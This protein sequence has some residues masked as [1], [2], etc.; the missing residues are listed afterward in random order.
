MYIRRVCDLSTQ[1]G[2]VRSD[3][4]NL[5]HFLSQYPSQQRHSL[6]EPS[7][8]FALSVGVRCES[9]YEFSTQITALIC[10]Q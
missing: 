3:C 4:L 9:A 7:V 5:F 6:F 8:L 10:E 1:S 2:V